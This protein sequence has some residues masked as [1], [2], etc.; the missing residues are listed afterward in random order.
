M[1]RPWPCWIRRTAATPAGHPASARR[2]RAIGISTRVACSVI[3][4]GALVGAASVAGAAD[5]DATKHARRYGLLAR[6]D[7]ILQKRIALD[8][9][10]ESALIFEPAWLRPSAPDGSGTT[11]QLVP[12]KRSSAVLDASQTVRR[13]ASLRSR[14]DIGATATV[15]VGST[16]SERTFFGL[17]M[18]LERETDDS[19]LRPPTPSF[20][21]QLE[22]NFD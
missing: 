12:L 4:C 18:W 3:C 14:A 22:H 17:R 10:L 21:L 13:T 2:S 16:F 9:H 15:A 5:L 1:S 11:R 6:G 19:H 8:G 7:T 20:G